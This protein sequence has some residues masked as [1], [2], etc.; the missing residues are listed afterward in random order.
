MK[1][2]IIVKSVY[3][4]I[5]SEEPGVVWTVEGKDGLDAF[6]EGVRLFTKYTTP[7]KS[8]GYFDIVGE[9]GWHGHAVEWGKLTK[10]G[11]TQKVWDLQIYGNPNNHIARI[12]QR[13]INRANARYMAENENKYCAWED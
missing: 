4:H 5:V 12:K 11:R 9:D 13:N 1:Y 2:E 6:I 7:A 8:P 10:N 3:N